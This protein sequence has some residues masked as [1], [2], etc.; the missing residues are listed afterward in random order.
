MSVMS[1]DAFDELN[2]MPRMKDTLKPDDLNTDACV[3]LAGEVLRGLAEDLA[4]AVRHYNASPTQENRRHLEAI[5]ALYRSNYFAALSCGMVDGNTA[6]REIIR[7][8]L[9]RPGRG[10][11]SCATCPD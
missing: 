3:D 9:R 4:T 5:K 2:G 7:N 8:A 11:R 6:I 10:G 1:S